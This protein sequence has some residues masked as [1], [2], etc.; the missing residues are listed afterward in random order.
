MIRIEVMSV[1]VVV[2]TKDNNNKLHTWKQGESV[3]VLNI[4]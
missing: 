4:Q 3:T 1:E 2:C